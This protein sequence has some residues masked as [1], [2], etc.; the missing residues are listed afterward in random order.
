MNM[1]DKLQ[2]VEDKF[3]EL[4]SLI[5]DPSVIADM[6]KWQR[7]SREHGN[8][9]PIV[10]AYR[11]YKRVCQGIEDDR[12]MLDEP[13]EDELRHMVEDELAEFK[14]RKEELDNELPILLLPKD[15]NDDKNV[16]VEI[17]GGVGGEE[18][19]LFA[20]DLFRMYTKFAESRGWK[21]EVSD[22]APGTAGGYKMIVFK[23]SSANEGVYGIMK[24]ES[25]VHRVQRVPQT[26]TQGRIQT[27]AASVAVFPEAGEFDIELNMSD[28]RKDTFCA[29][30]PGG[31]GVNTT[32]SAVRLTH[33]PSGIVVQCQEER[34]QLKNYDRA[35]E[36]LRTRLYNMEHQKYLDEIAKENR[37]RENWKGNILLQNFDKS[38]VI[39]RRID[40]HIGFDEKLQMVKT[41]V[42]KW[43]NDRLDGIDENLGKVITQA[44]NV[45]KQGRVNT[46]MLMKL[47]HLE[48]EDSEW[49]KAMRMLKESIIVKSSKQSINFK[50]KV[51][52]DSGEVW[53]TIVLNFNDIVAT[54]KK[55]KKDAE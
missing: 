17:R 12:A 42:D 38:L 29:S 51:K 39:E 44:F 8:L 37:V 15:P 25:G 30:G 9:V 5:S 45:D 28:I 18:A 33:I 14:V 23:L 40:D 10:E 55:E 35:L 36:E 46:A 6:D 22:Q 47:L 26:E 49:K 3:L 27:S 21:V 54:A 2:A 53:E 43:L 24:Y 7:Y 52:K 31:Q 4:E 16:I 41:I 1:I 13:M 20:G 11:E 32:Y 50:R 48:I 34:S 19:A